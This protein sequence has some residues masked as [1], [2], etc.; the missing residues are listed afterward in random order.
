MKVFLYI[1]DITFDQSLNFLSQLKEQN[2]QGFVFSS[3]MKNE[4]NR[5]KII[6]LGLSLI[7]KENPYE[8]LANEPGQN[9][10]VTSFEKFIPVNLKKGIYFSGFST[11]DLEFI[12]LPI[13]NIF[14]RAKVAD[15]LEKNLIEKLGHLLSIDYIVAPQDFWILVNG[16]YKKW[17]NEFYISSSPVTH[18]LLFNFSV[19]FF[20]KAS[21]IGVKENV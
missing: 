4:S 19:A 8:I 20:D 21:E 12:T 7:D 17:L 18:D 11:Y 16:V 5:K 2:K 13:S 6:D 3:S 15:L 9:V 1:S 10:L 14:Q